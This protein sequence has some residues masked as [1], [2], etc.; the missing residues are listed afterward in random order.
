MPGF[1]VEKLSEALTVRG[2]DI[3]D[4][5]VL[6][7]GLTYR[8]GAAETRA[9]PA[10]TIIDEL[11]PKGA[12]VAAIDPVLDDANEFRIQILSRSEIKAYDPTAIVVVRPTKSSMASSSKSSTT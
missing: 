7:L 6:V 10:R 2:T 11:R 8:L 5:R 9:T 1:T 12:E 4:A 3:P